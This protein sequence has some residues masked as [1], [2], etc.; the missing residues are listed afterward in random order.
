MILKQW[1]QDK[2]IELINSVDNIK[3]HLDVDM[4]NTV[5]RNL[6]SNGI[7][8]TQ[9]NGF[10]KI[11]A[12]QLENEVEISV[13]DNGI[14]MPETIKDKIFEVNTS[15]SRNGTNNEHGTGLGLILCKDFVERHGGRIAVESAEYKG[16]RF[17][18]TIPIKKPSEKTVPER[19]S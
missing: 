15:K 5:L 10:V 19:L 17:Y 11:T 6:I 2:R 7:K 4:I 9:Q 18:F 3:L 12:V 1:A 13:Q 14:G 16:T 8:Y